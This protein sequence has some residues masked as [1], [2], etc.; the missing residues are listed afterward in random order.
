MSKTMNQTPQTKRFSI[1]LG[2]E[3]PQNQSWLKIL[4]NEDGGFTLKPTEKTPLW[5]HDFAQQVK[6]NIEHKSRKDVDLKVVIYTRK[7]NSARRL[8][9]TIIKVV[10]KYITYGKVRN[11][12]VKQ[13]PVREMTEVHST[14]EI[15]ERI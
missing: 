12:N 6:K 14:F 5:E 9:D 3:L 8:S 15:I 4:K 11:W 13:I 10:E 7:D 2:G 1:T